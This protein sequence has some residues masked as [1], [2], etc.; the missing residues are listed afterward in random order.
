MAVFDPEHGGPLTHGGTFNNN[1][2]SVAAGV[3]VLGEVLTDEL[4]DSVNE[5]G[6]HLRV[7]LNQVFAKAGVEMLATGWGS[8]LTLHATKGPVLTPRDLASANDQLEELFF[9]DLLENGYYLAR[10][11]FIALSV[12][13]TDEHVNG[14]VDA[15][16]GWARAAGHLTVV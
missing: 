3:A 6:E 11:G 5:R 14:F 15:V 12:D 16:E 1:E 13:I 8:L 9:F 7:E 2:L 4:V 10:R